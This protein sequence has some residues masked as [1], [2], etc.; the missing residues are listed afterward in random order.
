VRLP[1]GERVLA[2]QNRLLE[3]QAALRHQATH[4]SLTG[5]WNRAMSAGATERAGPKSRAGLRRFALQT[6]DDFRELCVR[7]VGG[8]C[9][10]WATRR[11]AA[12]YT[13]VK[14]N[15]PPNGVVCAPGGYGAF[16]ANSAAPRLSQRS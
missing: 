15:T 6:T 1:S 13:V 10:R 4:D 3:A 16:G 11:S 2:F 9:P 12:P 7:P 14:E 5:L 8:C